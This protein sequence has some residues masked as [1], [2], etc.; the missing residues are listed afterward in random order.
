MEWY[1]PV[2]NSTAV[3]THL[4]GDGGVQA[5]EWVSSHQALLFAFL[6]FPEVVLYQEGGIKLP[7]G[8]LVIWVNRPHKRLHC[9]HLTTPHSI[10]GNNTRPEDTM[11]LYLSYR[12]SSEH[13]N[14]RLNTIYMYAGFIMSLFWIT[15]IPQKPNNIFLI[16]SIQD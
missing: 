3:E 8:Y 15:D 2:Q 4:E 6:E 5:G 7:H 11:V 12:N 14:N 16:Y 1:S 9:Q 13:S 10:L